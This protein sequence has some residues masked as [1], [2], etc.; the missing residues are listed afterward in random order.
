MRVAILTVEFP[1][2]ILGGTGT[3]VYNLATALTKQGTEVLV[4]TGSPDKYPTRRLESGMEVVSFPREPIPPRHLWFQFRS[5]N[6]IVKEISTCDVVHSQDCVSFPILNLCKRRGIGIPWV[7]TF[8]TNPLSEL[9]AI[10]HPGASLVDYESYVP[11]FPFWDMTDRIVPKAADQSV[12]VSASLRDELCRT[13]RIG[14]DVFEVI[15]NGINLGDFETFNNRRKPAPDKKIHLFYGGRLYY[16]K[17]IAHLL[18]IISSLAR[19][20]SED[21]FDLQIFGRGPLENSLKRYV[22]QHK[23]SEMVAFRGHVS[24]EVFLRS[25]SDCDIVCFPSLYEACPLLLMEAMAMRRPVIAFDRPFSREILGDESAGLLA[26]D[27]RDYASKLVSLMKSKD[28]RL[29]SGRR[30][31]SK[32]ASFDSAIT[33]SAYSGVYE[34]LFR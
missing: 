29:E 27:E 11:G 18:R 28:D 6:S 3:F 33:A 14:E 8:H 30:L 7:V 20:M 22:A 23:L 1:P 21:M 25:L 15:H 9:Y 32:A 34:R 24:R 19:G 17:G 31:R 5:M 10:S 4:I 16:R 2:T 13:Y 26:S 12:A